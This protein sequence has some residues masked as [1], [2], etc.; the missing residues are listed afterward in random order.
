MARL[1]RLRVMRTS[2]RR[3]Q[4]NAHTAHWR[5]RR[6]HINAGGAPARNIAVIDSEEILTNAGIAEARDIAR[7]QAL[8]DGPNRVLGDA[9]VIGNG[10]GVANR[11]P[12]MVTCLTD[13]RYRADVRV[14]R[15]VHH[16]FA[17]SGARCRE[18]IVE[19][20]VADQHDV[21]RD[22]ICV[23]DLRGG[24]QLVCELAAC[25]SRPVEQISQLALLAAREPG[26][27]TRR[28]GVALDGSARVCRTE[29]CRCAMSARSW[30][31]IRS[32]RSSLNRTNPIHQGPVRTASPTMATNSASRPSRAALKSAQAGRVGQLRSVVRRCAGNRRRCS[33]PAPGWIS[34]RHATACCA[35]FVAIARACRSDHG[36]VVDRPG[37]ST[38]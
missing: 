30:L 28:V 20:H 36:S 5:R 16:R 29:S 21:D 13:W 15:R 8:P 27:P 17:S 26:D 2:S 34:V 32:R 24:A 4:T 11:S 12:K 14:L 23:L 9:M 19:C 22:R 1:I 37:H 3:G 25:L 33:R 31:R 35:L 6:A 10:I 18:P 7:T 38:E